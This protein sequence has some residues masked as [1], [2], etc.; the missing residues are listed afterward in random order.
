MNYII[1]LATKKDCDTLSRL[2]Q[3]VWDE[4]Y[5]GIYSDSK[6]DDF[7]FDDN[8]EKFLSI[9]NDSDVELYVVEDDGTLV[10]YMSCGVPS[11]PYKDYNQS[12]NLLY[13]LKGYQRKGIGKKLFN[14]ACD[15]F[16]EK[17][18]H[19]FFICCNKLNINA[20]GFYKKMGGIIDE[21]DDDN[22]DDKS[23][24]QVKFLYKL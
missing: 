4:T 5:R 11:R 3:R 19:E 21:I 7:D 8:S 20:Q 12:I 22:N 1:R 15:R 6:I 18:C 10:G 24:S 2:K 16:K 23:I 9:I 14:I 17:G 13:L